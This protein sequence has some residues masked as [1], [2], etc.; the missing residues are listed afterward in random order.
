M[1]YIFP[2]HS[3]WRNNFNG[4]NITLV[5]DI[6]SWCYISLCKWFILC[7][8]LHAIITPQVMATV[9]A[10][11]S[12]DL[13]RIDLPSIYEP[14][15]APLALS[16]AFCWLTWSLIHVCNLS[17]A[18]DRWCILSDNIG[19]RQVHNIGT[20]QVGDEGTRLHPHPRYWPYLPGC[21]Y[22]LSTICAIQIPAGVRTYHVLCCI[23]D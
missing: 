13:V 23:G 22:P 21:F 7:L 11:L 10:H 19:T 8:W 1:V 17:K 16:T 12:V 5:M 20:W 18:S 9:R 2:S 3:L 15:Y 14:D 6:H 4:R